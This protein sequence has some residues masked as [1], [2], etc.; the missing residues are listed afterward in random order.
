[1]IAVIGDS[2]NTA[3]VR[4]HEAAGF[5]HTGVFRSVGWKFGRWLDTVLMQRTLGVGAGAGAQLGNAT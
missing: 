4:L 5:R 1:M 3:S 2:G